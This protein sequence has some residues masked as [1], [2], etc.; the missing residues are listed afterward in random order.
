MPVNGVLPIVSVYDANANP[1]NAE[2]LLNGNETY[3]VQAT[4]LSPG[5]TYYLQVSAAPSPAS[6]AGNYSLVAD[7]GGVPADLQTFVSGTLSQPGEQD[8]YTLYVA[9]TQLFQFVLSTE[10]GRDIH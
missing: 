9:Q 3:L 2:V 10:R 1:V 5:A 6:A 4:G 8:E 7:F